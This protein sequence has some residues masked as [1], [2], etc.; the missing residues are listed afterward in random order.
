MTDIKFVQDLKEKMQEYDSKKFSHIII[1]CIG[2]NKLVGDCIGPMV[3][4]KLNSKLKKQKCNKN[5]IIYGNMKHTLNFKNARQ[6]IEKIYMFY[7]KPFIITIDSALGTEKMIKQIVVDKGKIKIG[8]SLGRSIC[9]NSNINIKGVVGENKNT[10]KEN[11]QTLK[12]VKPELVI[13]LSNVV[14]NGICKSFQKII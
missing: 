11:I 1:L 8:N 9:Y 5:I 13:E 14:A 4:E 6:V 2:T 7:K 3:G 10:L 12:I